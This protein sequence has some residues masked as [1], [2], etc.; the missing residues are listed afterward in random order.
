MRNTQHARYSIDIMPCG[1]VQ[2]WLGCVVPQVGDVRGC[3]N[4]TGYNSPEY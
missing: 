4:I 1:S 3:R 2:F